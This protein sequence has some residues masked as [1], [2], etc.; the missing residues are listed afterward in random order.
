MV[1]LHR[2]GSATNGANPSSL[3]GNGFRVWQILDS[4]KRP[5]QQDGITGG[6]L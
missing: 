6:K 3:D 4:G 5:E 2:G 1:E